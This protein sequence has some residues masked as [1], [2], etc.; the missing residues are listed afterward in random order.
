M[1]RAAAAEYGECDMLKFV[2]STF[3][4][5]V[6]GSLSAQATLVSDQQNL[7]YAGSSVYRPDFMGI[8]GGTYAQSFVPSLTNMAGVGLFFYG[9]PTTVNPTHVTVSLWDSLPGSGNKL[10]SGAQAINFGGQYTETVIAWTP[11]PVNAAQTY[12]FSIQ[13]DSIELGTIMTQLDAYPRGGLYRGSSEAIFGAHTGWDM[14]FETFS[15]A[16]PS[17]APEPPVSLLFA[18]ATISLV[19]IKGLRGHR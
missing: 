7:P 3:A 11:V 1:R 13:T 4:V 9:I 10:A 19:G 2:L 16:S 5:L 17:S 18:V 15:E 8:Y 6:S 14:K 12:Y